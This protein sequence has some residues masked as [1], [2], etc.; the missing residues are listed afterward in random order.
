MQP[1][2]TCWSP[3]PV[4]T[5]RTASTSSPRPTRGCSVPTNWFVP[6][7]TVLMAH[8]GCT[9]VA[10]IAVD[11]RPAHD[12]R[13]RDGR[14][15]VD[16]SSVAPGGTSSSQ[17]SG[18]R[19]TSWPTSRATSPGRSRQ[20]QGS[21]V[22]NGALQALDGEPAARSHAFRR[23]PG[24]SGAGTTPPAS[25]RRSAASCVTRQRSDQASAAGDDVLAQL[26]AAVR[27]DQRLDQAAH[28]RLPDQRLSTSDRYPGPV[29]SQPYSRSPPDPQR[30][31]VERSGSL[32]CSTTPP[33]A[34]CPV[35]FHRR[36]RRWYEPVVSFRPQSLMLL[37][38]NSSTR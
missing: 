19:A 3:P 29:D 5:A 27:R 31:H 36:G 25:Q 34:A 7:R 11:R 4:S 33:P 28:Q 16:P 17:P 13:V 23:R 35:P 1:L 2:P 9:G 8:G 21:P 10:T 26:G 37:D 18:S 30:A 15:T 22:L 24:G 20:L 6:R 14:D 12:P 38:A 32:Q